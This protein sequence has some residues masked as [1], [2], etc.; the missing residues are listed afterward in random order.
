MDL[1]G[2][3][4]TALALSVI[5]CAFA[6]A[7]F[8]QEQPVGSLRLLTQT[9]EPAPATPP[10]ETPVAMR[11]PARAA[12]GWTGPLNYSP[13]GVVDLIGRLCRPAIAGDGGDI[14]ARAQE[15]GLGDPV[16]ARED[17]TRA[18]PPGAVTWAVPSLDGELYLFGYGENPLRCG[19]V[20]ARPMPEAGFNKVLDLLQGPE[21]G[22]VSEPAQ[23]LAGNVH[24][25]RLR[26]AKHEF[27]D[28]MEYPA[29]DDRPG[30]LRADF[31]PE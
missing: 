7:A 17:I 9:A 1:G 19:A 24:W 14:I 21:Q 20:V 27:V 31:L 4:K 16:P 29:T 22:F 3:M 18:L 5:L 28:V 30:V 15:F 6:P 23:V 8:A 26:S 13:A 25:A 12:S 11:T 10:A 2:Y